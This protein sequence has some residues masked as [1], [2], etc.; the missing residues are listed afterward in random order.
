MLFW[1]LGIR[2]SSPNPVKCMDTRSMPGRWARSCRAFSFVF[3]A[4]IVFMCF[5]SAPL[6]AYTHVLT[7]VNESVTCL[8][9][10][11]LVTVI[12]GFPSKL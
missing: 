4:M 5:C 1:S 2:L 3:P 9:G 10:V 7:L 11:A 12:C 6:R 8:A